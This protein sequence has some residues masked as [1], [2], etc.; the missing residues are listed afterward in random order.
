MPT[1][2][3]PLLRLALTTAL[4][5]SPLACDT[6]EPETTV[7][8]AGQFQPSPRDDTNLGCRIDGVVDGQGVALLHEL[9]AEVDTDREVK[10]RMDTPC[11]STESTMRHD[12]AGVAEATVVAPPGASCSLT[13]TVEIANDLQVCATGT[14]SPQVCAELDQLCAEVVDDDPERATTGQ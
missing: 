1:Q 11:T 5:A 12:A 8:L 9:P 2:P 3:H 10:I 14:P 13:V 6:E 7:W 4:A